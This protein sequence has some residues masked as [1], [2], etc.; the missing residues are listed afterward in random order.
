MI[1]T[2]VRS[3]PV[4]AIDASDRARKEFNDLDDLKNS[5]KE[6]NI[7]HPI[8]VC[9]VATNGKPYKLL[10]GERRLRS[11]IACGMENINAVVYPETLTEWQMKE[12]ELLENAA[13]IRKALMPAEEAILIKNI[14]E[15]RQGQYGKAV[16]RP[17]AGRKGSPE[18]KGWSLA[19]TAKMFGVSPAKVSLDIEIAQAAEI[20]PELR[21]MNKRKDVVNFIQQVIRTGVRQTAAIKA[22]AEMP[23]TEKARI[24]ALLNSFIIGDFFELSRSLPN[25]SFEYLD[26]DPPYGKNMDILV[27]SAGADA[28]TE[29]KQ[30]AYPEFLA[31]LAP[32]L[33][34]LAAPAA[35][36]NFWHDPIWEVE[37]RNILISAGWTV[38]PVRGIWLKNFAKNPDPHH[39]LTPIYEQFYLCIKGKPS[40]MVPAT[41]AVFSYNVVTGIDREHIAERPIKLI[42]QLIRTFTPPGGKVLSPFVGSGVTLLA[43]ANQGVN[44]VGYELHKKHKDNF[45]LRVMEQQY[46]RYT[47][48]NAKS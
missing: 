17:G 18:E 32:L 27:S 24:E 37:V 23:Q 14:H 39:N 2:T 21:T 33:Y 42:E 12:I 29:I 3:I 22:Q 30:E 44:A 48:E 43:A 25:S 40:L 1:E 5:I 7:W 19:D 45:T 36:M 13:N 15:L 28:Y 47:N 16:A 4:T 38:R 41:N 46:G 6:Y 11:A 26:V 34:K 10:A 31:R 8:A 9:E 35:Y 20:I